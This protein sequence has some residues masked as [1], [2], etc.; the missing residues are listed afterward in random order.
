MLSPRSFR[1]AC[2]GVSF[3]TFV[4]GFAEAASPLVFVSSF[5]PKEKGGI[6]A[7]HLDVAAARL[8]PAKRTAE[9]PHPFFFAV[10]PDQKLLYS[11]HAD[12]FGSKEPEEIAAFRLEGRDGQLVPLNRRT[13]RGTA[14]CYVDVDP[15]GGVILIANYSSGDVISYRKSEAGLS[16]P[17][18]FVRH[19]GSSVNPSR[20][21]EP[22]AH[23]FVIAP[24]GKFAYA[25]DLGT[26]QILCYR[27]D[28]AAGA[29]TAN[30]QSFVRLPPGSG[31]RHLTFHPNGR[32]MYVINELTNT[33][34]RFDFVA[35]T[36]FL[37]ERETLSTLPADFTGTSHT[38]DL[39]ITPNG[40]FLYGTNRGHDSLA[41]YRIGEDGRLTLIEIVPSLGK[42]P[43]N[44]AITPDGTLLLC[45]NMA[46]SNLSLFRI[47]ETGKISSAGD[48]IEITSPSCIRILP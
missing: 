29:L 1:I 37:I 14:S 39:K 41:A 44:L 33:V 4:A 2:L 15:T 5:A 42:G 40:K 46:G 25:A 34:T 26:D 10:S 3:M 22:H 43:Q 48:P 6:Q 9:I 8:T 7:F 12:K 21:K 35:D 11:I 18:S 19:A 13:T 30:D 38:A 24:G 28:A 32:W 23:C 31:P 36:G 45:A 47:G 20:Q 17:V 16:E 27:L